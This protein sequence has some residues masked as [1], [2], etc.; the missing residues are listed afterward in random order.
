MAADPTVLD[1]R[2]GTSDAGPPA[3]RPDAA[4]VVTT[5]AAGPRRARS[6]PCSSFA[7]AAAG[8][9]GLLFMAGLV[10]AAGTWALSAGAVS[11]TVASVAGVIAMEACEERTLDLA[12]RPRAR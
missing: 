11:L 4:G 1:A 8:S 7:W 2:A 9:G 12:P 3:S 10:E 6:S 5:V